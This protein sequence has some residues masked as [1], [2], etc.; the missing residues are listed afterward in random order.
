MCVLDK[1]LPKCSSVFCHMDTSTRVLHIFFATP[2]ARFFYVL[3][4]FGLQGDHGAVPS[5][6][7]RWWVT[8]RLFVSQF[9]P[10]LSQPSAQLFCSFGA[11]GRG[12][13][14]LPM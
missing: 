1:D 12:G 8:G 11:W 4:S 10:L 5:V 3:G 9:L 2:Q 13:E 6:T 7:G 14:G